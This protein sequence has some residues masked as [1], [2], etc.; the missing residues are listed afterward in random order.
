VSD[1]LAG[2]MVDALPYLVDAHR[3]VWSTDVGLQ[4]FIA[5]TR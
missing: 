5:R 2:A 1:T 3:Q 4:R